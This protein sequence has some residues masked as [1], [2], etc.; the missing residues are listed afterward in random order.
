MAS[1]NIHSTAIVDARAQVGAGSEVGPYCVVGPNVKLGEGC[2]LHSHVVVDGLTTIGARCEFYPF[3]CIGLK[4][5]D[6]KYSGGEVLPGDRVGQR[7]SGACDGAY[8]DGGRAEARGSGRTTI[9]W[10]IRMWRMTAW[11]GAM[12]YSATTG[13]GGTCCGGRLCDCG[14]A[15]GD[16]SILPDWEDGDHRGVREGGA[17]YTAIYDRG[18]EPGGDAGGEQGGVGAQRGVGG[19]PSEPAGGVQDNVSSGVDS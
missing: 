10:R 11:W 18:R 3:A 12:W 14:R 1:S 2:R 19:G 17:G 9:F 6:L 7:V 5:Q 4:T 13:L 16:P 8:G 15:G